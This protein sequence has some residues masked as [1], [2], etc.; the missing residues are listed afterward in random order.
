MAQNPDLYH[1]NCFCQSDSSFKKLLSLGCGGKTACRLFFTIH[2]RTFPVF[3]SLSALRGSCPEHPFYLF[4][5]TIHVT[6]QVSLFVSGKNWKRRESL[7]SDIT[8]TRCTS[9]ADNGTSI[10]VALLQPDRC[11]YGRAEIWWVRVHYTGEVFDLAA[12]QLTDG[13]GYSDKRGPSR[14]PARFSFLKFLAL[15][16]KHQCLSFFSHVPSVLSFSKIGWSIGF[17][18]FTFSFLWSFWEEGLCRLMTFYIEPP[19]VVVLLN[20]CVHV[21]VIVNEM[22]GNLDVLYIVYL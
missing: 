9:R 3:H 17:S 14:Q 21:L 8:P 5:A 6:R 10:Q 13:T 2:W 22:L 4:L 19:F 11:V 1:W 15:T 12:Q 18:E 7:L 20:V 16:F